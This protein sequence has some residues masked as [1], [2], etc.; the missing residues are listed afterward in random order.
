[1]A[2]RLLLMALAV[3]RMQQVA[4]QAH[5]A[6]LLL[7]RQELL[8]LWPP[9]LGLPQLQLLHQAAAVTQQQVPTMAAV[10][11]RQ[12]LVLAR[13][14]AQVLQTAAGRWNW[15][16]QTA[17]HSTAQQVK[18]AAHLCRRPVWWQ[19]SSRLLV[20]SL[21]LAGAAEALLVPLGLQQ[22]WRV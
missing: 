18:R 17:Q 19:A 8:L 10:A 7:L 2:L 6:C 12:A 3:Q 21:Q 9:A 20:Q 22:P 14:A 5:Q 13:S 16:V 1:M 4:K 11:A 15:R